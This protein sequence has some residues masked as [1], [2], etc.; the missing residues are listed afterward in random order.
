MKIKS[1]TNKTLLLNIK[2]AYEEGTDATAEFRE[3]L[4]AGLQAKGIVVPDNARV[5]MYSNSL[6]ITWTE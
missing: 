5:S 6:T 2:D 3:I 1:T 4:I